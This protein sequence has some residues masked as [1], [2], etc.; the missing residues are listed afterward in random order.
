[1]LNSASPKNIYS[2]N[3]EGFYKHNSKIEMSFNK[4]LSFHQ[5]GV[6]AVERYYCCHKIISK[7][8]PIV[9]HLCCFHFYSL[10]IIFNLFLDLNAFK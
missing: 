3:R 6:V 7:C 5:T 4:V 10:C 8:I 2:E 9:D 1:M